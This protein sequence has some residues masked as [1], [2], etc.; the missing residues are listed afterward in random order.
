MRN[1]PALGQKKCMPSQSCRPFSPH[2]NVKCLDLTLCTSP[3]LHFSRGS[4]C[5]PSVLLPN[6]LEGFRICVSKDDRVPTLCAHRQPHA[7]QIPLLPESYHDVLS[8]RQSSSTSRA[9]RG[10]RAPVLFPAV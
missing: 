4:N 3:P 2:L 8:P 10:F 5:W 1:G 9:C 6:L 7:A